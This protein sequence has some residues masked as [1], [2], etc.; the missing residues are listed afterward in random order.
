MTNK[1]EKRKPAFRGKLDRVRIAIW[2][3]RNR[4]GEPFYSISLSRAYSTAGKGDGET[5]WHQTNTFGERDLVSLT[6]ALDVAKEW[7]NQQQKST[8]VQVN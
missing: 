3:N 1:N 2:E 4:E 8:E 7:L 5:I 6:R